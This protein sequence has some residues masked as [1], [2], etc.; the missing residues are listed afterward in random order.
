MAI[1]KA[2]RSELRTLIRSRFRVLRADVKVRQAELE[3]EL[4]NRVE[5]KYAA[6]DKQYQD[7][8]YLVEQARDEAN[9]KANDIL[10]GTGL[11]PDYPTKSDYRL[12]LQNPFGKPPDDRGVLLAKGYARIEAQVKSANLE[13]DRQENDLLTKL[14]VGALESDEAKQFLN[15]IPTVSSLVPADRLLAM[16]GPI[17]ADAAAIEGEST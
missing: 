14:L 7:A 13:L 9:R 11:W 1:T 4:R 12:I 15:E 6:A 2:E 5:T 17:G 8:M 3:L 16:V 10:R